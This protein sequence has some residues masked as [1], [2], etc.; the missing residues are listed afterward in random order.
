MARK[1]SRSEWHQQN[2]L[3]SRSLGNRGLRVRLFQKRSGG[4]FYRAIWLPEKGFDRRCLMTYDRTEA[5]QLGKELLA[6]LLRNEE[7]TSAETLTL[8]MLWDRYSR[9]C[10]A[11]LDNSPRSRKDAE[12]HAEVLLAF[13]GRDCDVRGLSEQDQLAFTRK[14]LAGGIVCTEKRKTSAVRTRSVEVDLQLLHT[15]LRWAVTVRSRSGK[16]LLDH[17][18]LAGIRRPREK[19]PKRPVATWERYLA[20]RQALADLI[21]ES[22]SDV[23]RRKWLKLDLALTLA[24]ATGR[25]LGAIRQLKWDDVD[26]TRG[27][28]RWRAETDKKGKEWVIPIPEPLR[29]ELRSFRVRMGGA[30]GGLLCPSQSNP[31]QAVSRDTF[32]HLL[33]KAERKAGLSKLDGSL[34]HAYRRAWATARKHLSVV[35]VAAAGGWSDIGTLLKCYQHADNETLLE[36]MTH[37]KKISEAASVG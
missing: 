2:G 13:F 14:R 26:L 1:P 37:S 11:F 6:A 9:E 25:R 22:K 12:G 19:N 3:W 24:E 27:T 30:F 10:V 23:T 35:D 17:N 4:Q 21:V 33:A 36:V 34:W 29:D 15:M 31:E 32:G 18:P 20:T 7:I 28:I 8:G 5:E 16:R